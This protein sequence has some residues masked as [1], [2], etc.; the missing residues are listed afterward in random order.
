MTSIAIQ[1]SSLPV[2]L[3]E[4]EPSVRRFSGIANSGKPFLLNG[5]ATVLDLSNIYLKHKTAVLLQHDPMCRAGV[6]TLSVT[7]GGLVANGILFN[8]VLTSND[9]LS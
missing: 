9:T 7:D 5:K 1:L 6:A 4:T 8:F 2:A 3:T